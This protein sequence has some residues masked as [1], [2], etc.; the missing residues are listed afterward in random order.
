[1]DLF[2]LYFKRLFASALIA[3]SMISCNRQTTEN[4]NDSKLF[5]LRNDVL[6]FVGTPD[7]AYSRSSLVFSDQGAWFG[8]GLHDETHQ[9]MGFSGP[10]LMTQENGVWCSQDLVK[11]NINGINP[12][13]FDRIQTSDNSHLQQV[14]ESKSLRIKQDLHFISGSSVLISTKVTNLSTK[15]FSLQSDFS[16]RLFLEGMSIQGIKNGISLQSDKSRAIGSVKLCTGE[17]T[18]ITVEKESYQ[19]SLSAIDLA[20]NETKEFIV[21]VSFIFPE[22][23]RENENALIVQ[24]AQDYDASLEV[25]QLEKSKQINSLEK[26]LDANW[27]DDVYKDLLTKSVLTLQNNWRIPTG[28]LKHAGVFPSYHY[29]WFNGFWAWDSWKHAAALA[30]YDVELAKNQIRAMYDFQDKNGFI[31]DCIYRDTLI[32]K[33]NYRNTKA[34]LSGWAVWEVFSQDQD[35]K[36]LNELYPLVKKQHTWWYQFRDHDQDGLC[37]Y[38]STDGSLIAAK[39][40]SGMDNAV[41]FDESAILK[42]RNGAYSLNQE[43]VD[44]NAYLFA[45]KRFLLEMAN[46]LNKSEDVKKLQKEMEVLKAQIQT[47]F[48]DKK[49]GWFYDVSLDGKTFVDVMG[50]EG[51]IPLWAGCATDNQ[52][53]KVHKNI[54]NKQ[55]FN[56]KVPLPTLSASHPKFNPDGGYWRGPNWLD[57]SYFGVVGLHE[58]GF[59]NDA[60][61]LTRKLMH[62]AEGVLQKGQAIR[63]NYNPMTGDGLESYNFSWSAAHYLLLLLNE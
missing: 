49:T 6:N 1:M 23:T 48:F 30:H 41:R 51:W 52:A 22:Y 27:T 42:N 57:Q 29:V 17:P 11:F 3:I 25:R 24:A 34:P 46:A 56:T 50:C 39:W 15:K 18:S 61:A 16:G 47:T 36:F 7:S 62:N 37:E 26:K 59:H 58:Y 13:E 55:F 40:E 8:F 63:E 9:S 44:L 35:L 10:F 21:A 38:G 14:F 4:Q 2:K 60:Y 53:R 32:E 31:P 45:E 19:I 12:E 5:N 43:S 28:E 33:H 20:Q 54:M